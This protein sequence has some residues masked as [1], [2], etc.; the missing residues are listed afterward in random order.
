MV[1]RVNRDQTIEGRPCTPPHPT[2]PGTTTRT[3]SRQGFLNELFNRTAYRYRAIDKVVG[4]GSGLWYRRTALR[5]AGLGPG[6]RVL[7]VACGPG[8][9]T[10]CALGLV[11]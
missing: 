5:G 10:Q 11:G 4:F 9:T 6:M 3:K 8:L 1:A 7:D 2:L